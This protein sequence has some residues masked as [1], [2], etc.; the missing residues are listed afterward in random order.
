MK[1][2]VILFDFDDTLV[3]E[4]ASAE[5]AFLATCEHVCEEYGLIIAR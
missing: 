4:E 3:V 5:E 1:Y 2:K